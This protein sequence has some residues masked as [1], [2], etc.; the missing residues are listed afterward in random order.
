MLDLRGSWHP[1]SERGME[2][3]QWNVRGIQEAG[4]YHDKG[5]INP[6]LKGR[7]NSMSLPQSTV[8][9]FISLD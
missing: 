7:S 5:N 4:V 3:S 1:G 2:T 6:E 9:Y 8:I